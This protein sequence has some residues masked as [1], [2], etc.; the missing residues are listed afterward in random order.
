M[1]HEGFLTVAEAM[2]PTTVSVNG[3]DSVATAADIMRREGL[4]G[5]PVCAEDRVVGLVTPM[6]LLKEPP[7]RSVGA[8]MM[9][10]ITPAA[11]DLSLMQVY[12]L[13]VRQ[14]VEVL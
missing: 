14:G 7:Y 13:M 6:Q 5:L 4:M 9:R 2:V 3:D 8:V 10:E 12:T 1:T 11:P